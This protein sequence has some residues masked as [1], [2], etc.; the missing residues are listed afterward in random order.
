MFKRLLII[1]TILSLVPL[2]VFAQSTGKIVGQIVDQATGE[3]LPGV[4]VT[5]DNTLLGANTDFDGYYVILNVPVGA[6]T[7]RASF[8]GFQEVAMENARVSANVTTDINFD[9]KETPLELEEVITI[10]AERP[11]VEKNITQSYSL[12]TSETIE[13]IPVRGVTNILNLQPSVVVQDG[14]VYIRGGRNEEVGYYL[15]GANIVNPTN[16]TRAVHIIQE[17]IEEIQVLAGGYTAE[18]GGANSGII[19]TD[20][21]TGAPKYHVSLDAQTDNF[22]GRGEKFLNS[23]S[24]GHS[25]ITGTFSGP[26]VDKDIRLFVAVENE[27]QDDWRKRFTKGFTFEDLVDVQPTNPDVTDGH[28]DTVSL[29]YGDGFT[30]RNNQNR[31]A[32]NSTL[33]FDLKPFQV[34]LS[35]VFSYTKTRTSDNFILNMLN[36]RQIWTNNWTG[37]ISAKFTHVLNPTTFYDVKVSYYDR[38]TEEEDAW[39]GNDWTKWSD[40]ASVSDYTASKYGEEGRVTYR[41]HHT[42]PYQYRLL[43]IPFNRNGAEVGNYDKSEQ[44]YIGANINFVTQFNKYNEVKAGAD[45]RYYTVRAYSI[46]PDV[47]SQLTQFGGQYE[48]LADIPRAVFAEQAGNTYGYDYL[49]EKLDEGFDG[50]RHPLFA[51]FYV[52]DKL[53]FKDLIINAGLRFDYFDSDD[54]T[55]AN[56][57]NFGVDL[58]TGLVEDD[59][60]VEKD[61]TM[62]ISPRLGISFPITERTVFYA[63]YGKFIQMPEL[64]DIY[65]NANQFARQ[66]IR[67]GFYY[68]TPTGYGADPMRTTQYEVGFRQAIGEVAAIDISGFYK[69]VIG[70]PQVQKVQAESGAQNTT[71]WTIA[72]GDFT[73]TKGLEF[74]LTLRR[75]ERL[76]AQLNYTLSAAEGTGA[77]ETAYY[78]S[79]YLGSQIPTTTS[80]LDYSQVHRGTLLLDYRFGPDDGGPILERLGANVVFNFNSGHPYTFSY[81]NPGGQADPYTAGTDYMFDTRSREALESIN[82]STTPWNFNVDLRLDKTFEIYDQLMATAYIRVT[83]LFNTKNVV[84][85]FQT[86]GTANDDGYISNPILYETFFNAY[87]A[88]YLDLYK[89]MNIDNGQAYLDQTGRE[90]YGTPRQIFLGLKLSY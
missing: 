63:Q 75:M 26:V 67:G 13:S 7:V 28:P 86:T 6:Y 34:R 27:Y 2:A 56:R 44:N 47:M 22:V 43:G 68:I 84:N 39:F 45:F 17:A 29:R 87:G 16:N 31:W 71:Y 1:F 70:Q 78:S 14:N 5:I 59:A 4:N 55:L 50:A 80:P 65:Y 77:S 46:N 64:N 8:I 74:K 51:S 69:N 89:A 12:V 40:S 57:A 18:F 36:D 42:G 33:L 41:R 38:R 79:V 3:P 21:K 53:E 20:L 88:E 15:D 62:Q 37:L 19:K 32:V 76:Q 73:T 90:L 54:N 52:Q 81:A 72:N 85:V 60:W 9:L 61:P 30:P 83:N 25:I 58:E 48:T 35:G 10:T 24:Y 11:L 23:Y 49:G 66:I 82:A